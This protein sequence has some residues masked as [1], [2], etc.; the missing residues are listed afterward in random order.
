MY[1]P[2]T[3]QQIYAAIERAT[4]RQTVKDLLKK[5]QILQDKRKQLHSDQQHTGTER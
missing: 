3:L 5:A 2:T 1:D 4:D